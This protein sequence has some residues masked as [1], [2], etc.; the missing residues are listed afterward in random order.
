MNSPYIQTLTII[1]QVFSPGKVVFAGFGVLL[2]VRPLFRLFTRAAR[3][4]HIP[5]VAKDIR[6]S[7]EMLIDV[8][9]R[10]ENFLRRLEVYT[11]VAPTPEMMDMMVKIMVEVLS[12]LAIAT[13]EMRQGR[14]SE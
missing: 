11:A 3:N 9:E 10:I 5:Q 13:K 12:I 14:T 6:S 8:F 1:R 7:Q 4:S 2:L